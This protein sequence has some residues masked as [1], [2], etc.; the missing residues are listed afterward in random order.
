MVTFFYVCCEVQLRFTYPKF[1]LIR[2][3]GWRSIHPC[4]FDCV[5]WFNWWGKVRV[6][7]PS[8]WQDNKPEELRE[9]ALQRTQG[10]HPNIHMCVH[11]TPSENFVKNTIRHRLNQKG[12]D[13]QVMG[14]ITLAGDASHP[15]TPWLGQG[16]CMAM[17][18]A[19]VLARNLSGA[20]NL[21]SQ[22]QHEAPA[23]ATYNEYDC[24]HQAL[25]DYQR[26]RHDRT[27]SL[28]MQ[29]YMA[30]SAFRSESSLYCFYRNW[31]LIPRSFNKATFLKHTLFDVGNLPVGTCTLPKD[32][33][34]K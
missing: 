21:K 5:C 16:A 22:L 1:W 32:G 14:G 8:G 25:L 15:M 18:D 28:S 12:P 3:C 20:F 24:I 2:G 6:F 23:P 4:Q 31:F 29:S 9:E 27:S 34:T 11:N 17:E 10:W 26:E 33:V 30:G 19:I 13:S 7:A